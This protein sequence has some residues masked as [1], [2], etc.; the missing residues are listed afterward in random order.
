MTETTAGVRRQQTTVEISEQDR[1]R[2]LADEQR[3][4]LV[5]VLAGQTSPVTLTELATTLGAR[6]PSPDGEPDT[7]RT[8]EIRLHHVHLPLLAEV[9]VIDY[10]QAE[11]RV[12]PRQPRLR[13]LL[14]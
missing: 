3:R 9:G 11:Q 1:C 10:D 13:E 4:T 5:S 12:E 6:E 8:I 2:L 14:Q 7:H